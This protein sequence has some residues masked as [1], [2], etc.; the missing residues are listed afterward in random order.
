MKKEKP[1]EI[2]KV[3]WE[4]K[5]TYRLILLILVLCIGFSFL[6]VP[7][8][9][10]N[11]KIN[12]YKG[13]TTG[14]VLSIKENKSLTQGFYGQKTFISYYEV[15]FTYTVNRKTYRNVNNLAN[16]GKYY[17]FVL[18]IYKSNYSRSVDVEYIE[19]NPQESLILVE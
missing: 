13:R 8:Y 7:E 19:N 9:L 17:Q 5:S 12:N 1:P 14:T 4:R 2:I 18:S 10:R 15:I 16:E 6:L 3:T 11:I